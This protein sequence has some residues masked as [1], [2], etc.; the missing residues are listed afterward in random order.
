M[1]LTL[2][3]RA[4]TVLLRLHDAASTAVRR[5]R[6]HARLAYLRWLVASA[7][8]DERCA[9]QEAQRSGWRGRAAWRDTHNARADAARARQQEL[10]VE[11][12]GVEAALWPVRGAA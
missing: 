6:L 4:A 10:R 1:K 8:F 3:L 9:E 5:L 12:A 11:I 2:T 7:E